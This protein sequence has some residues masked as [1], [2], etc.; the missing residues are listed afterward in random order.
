MDADALPIIGVWRRRSHRQQLIKD[1]RH[2]L[3]ETS[4]ILRKYRTRISEEALREVRTA[5]DDLAGALRRRNVEQMPVEIARLNEQLDRYL[6][7]GRKS[8]AREWIESVFAAVFVALLLRAFVIEAFKIPSGSMLPMLEIGDHLF[9]NKF[10]YGLQVPFTHQ[11]LVHFGAP[12][13][14]EVIVFIYP[15]EESKDFIKRVVAMGGDVI[16]VR[17]NRIVLNGTAVERHALREPCVYNDRDEIDG[18]WIQHSCQ[19]FEEWLGDYHYRTI[20]TQ[21]GSL[22]RDFPPTKIPEGHVFVM[23]DNRDNSHDSR[24]WGTVPLDYIKGKAMFIWW[25][26]G[27]RGF[28]WTR[29]FHGVHGEPVVDAP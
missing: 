22:L 5:A 17:Q 11:K 28:R 7:W 19:A 8:A 16:E 10:L 25:S 20:E 23:G 6:S 12:D 29:L 15:R 3:R 13:R 18:Q 24:Y 21:G 4:R 9:V 1:A 27:P 26:W 2:L 14:G